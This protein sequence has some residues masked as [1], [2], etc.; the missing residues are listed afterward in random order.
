MIQLELSEIYQ[1]LL[2]LKLP[3][4]Y[5]HFNE[6]QQLPYI[7]YHEAG[8]NITGADNLNLY[9]NASI[10]VELYTADKDVSLERSIEELFSD[11]ELEKQA[12]TYLEGEEMHFTSYSFNTIQKMGG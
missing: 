4:A 3:V 11:T 8:T 10:V 12:D 1:R 2:T 6:P 5:L 7:A 9:R